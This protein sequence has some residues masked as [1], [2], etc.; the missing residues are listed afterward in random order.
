MKY[1][2]WALAALALLGGMDDTGAG[3]VNA[4]MNMHATLLFGC[5]VIG[6]T[7]DFGGVQAGEGGPP[8]TRSHVKVACPRGAA[9]QVGINDGSHGRRR[10]E[11]DTSFDYLSYELYKS[12]VGNDRFGD[13]IISQRVGG[14][15]QGLTIFVV[16]PVYGEIFPDQSPPGGEY[17]DNAVITVYF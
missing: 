15:G 10:M 17:L 2:R 13:A 14:T 3:T 16:I 4:N 7:L 11:H 12:S 8:R 1:L 9:F 5:S 6:N